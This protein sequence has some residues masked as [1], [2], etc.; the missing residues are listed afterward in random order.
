MTSQDDA[1]AW[2]DVIHSK[3]VLFSPD[4]EPGDWINTQ[5]GDFPKDEDLDLAQIHLDLRLRP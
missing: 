2:R 5:E 3:P 4:P 1:P